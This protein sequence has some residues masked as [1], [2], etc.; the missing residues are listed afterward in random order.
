[1]L[2][3]GLLTTSASVSQML[4]GSGM[5][6]SA[7]FAISFLGRHLNKCAFA[8][9][10]TEHSGKTGVVSASGSAQPGHAALSAWCDAFC[11]GSAGI[12]PWRGAYWK[13]SPASCRL[14]LWL[15]DLSNEPLH[16]TLGPGAVGR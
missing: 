5:V 7:V 8:T 4:R 10:R 11:I 1:M 6:F 16:G 2:Q 13:G 14:A 9:H 12:L 3:V 15:P